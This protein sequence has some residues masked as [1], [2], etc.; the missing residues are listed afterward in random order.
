TV[1]HLPS[2]PRVAVIVFGAACLAGTFQ[3]GTVETWLV[4]A[5][6]IFIA[7]QCAELADFTSHDLT[8]RFRRERTLEVHGKQVSTMLSELELQGADLLFTADQNGCLTDVSERLAAGLGRSQERLEGCP[9]GKLFASGSDREAMIEAIVARRPF[10]DLVVAFRKGEETGYL[11]VSGRFADNDGT[12]VIRGVVRDITRQRLAETRL[13]RIG[14]F[15]GLT[16]LPN[17]SLFEEEAGGRINANQGGGRMALLFVDL[18]HFKAANDLHGHRTGDALLKAAANQLRVAAGPE[19]IVARYGGDE[20]AVLT[21]NLMG[22]GQAEALA[23]RLVAAIS[24]PF[25]QDALTLRPTASIGV[26]MTPDDGTTLDDLLHAADLALYAAKDAG[27]NRWSRFDAEMAAAARHRHMIDAE[28]QGAEERGE[29]QL[30][31]QPLVD[32]RTLK[33]TGFEALVRWIHPKRGFISPADFIP[34]A[35]ETGYIEKLGEWIMRTAIADAARWPAHINIA[36][37]VSPLQLRTNRIEKIIAEAVTTSRMPPSRIE[38][39][40]TEGALLQGSQHLRTLLER[41][42]AQGLRF[43]L[44]DFG[45]GF[46]SLSYLRTF[47]F[48]KLKVDKSFVD[49]IQKGGGSTAIVRA[50]INLAHELGMVTVAE[51]IEHAGQLALLQQMKCRQIQGYLISRPLPYEDA[52]AFALADAERNQQRTATSG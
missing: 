16:D 30:H 17:R 6:I 12:P 31:Y 45:T 4:M 28:M 1:R 50:V 38:L 20:F 42:R 34:I 47:P 15:D 36:I 8:R 51:G 32:A 23:S 14:R 11:S 39:E 25:R 52:T 13:D 5:G 2:A 48:H 19:A 27:R 18:D 21:G 33:L 37:N 49:D 3:V 44:D 10:R 40:I 43:S 46:S 41:L 7:W 35:E 26:A 24:E 22:I 9:L 29:F